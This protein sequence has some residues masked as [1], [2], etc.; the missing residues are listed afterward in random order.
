V[1]DNGGNRGGG[2]E[3]REPFAVTPSIAPSPIIEIVMLD[4]VIWR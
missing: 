1:R 4:I 2:C 3:R